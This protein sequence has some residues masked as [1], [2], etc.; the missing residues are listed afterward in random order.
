VLFSQDRRPADAIPALGITISIVLSGEKA[1]ANLNAFVMSSQDVTSHLTNWTLFSR[2][3]FCLFIIVIY[4]GE[5][6]DIFR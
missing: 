3:E 6:R 1:R 4:V 2:S 5:I